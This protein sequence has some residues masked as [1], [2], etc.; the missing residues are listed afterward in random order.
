MFKFEWLFGT[1]KVELVKH[2]TALAIGPPSPSKG[3][4]PLFLVL[5]SSH[6]EGLVVGET[7]LI[8][9]NVSILHNV[10]L[11][12]TSKASGDRHLKIGDG[13]LIGPGTCILGNIKIGDGAKIG[14]C[15]V[16]LKEVPPRTTIVGNPARVVGGKDNP[17]KL[18]K[19]PSFT[20]DHTS[21]SDYVI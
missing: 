3:S 10:T 20:M 1:P 4:L 9:N 12:G 18:D 2:V 5:S 21:W 14:A 19:M 15:F 8:G 17:I 11:G 13:V 16:V 7:T 6:G